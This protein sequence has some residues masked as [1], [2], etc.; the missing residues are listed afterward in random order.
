MKQNAPTKHFALQILEA[1]H[2]RAL[3]IMKSWS[4]RFMKPDELLLMTL[5]GYTLPADKNDPIHEI[6]SDTKNAITQVIF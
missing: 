5:Y 4:A 6:L 1:K 3:G 2:S